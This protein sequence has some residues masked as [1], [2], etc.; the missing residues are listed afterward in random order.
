MDQVIIVG[1]G[2]AGVSAACWLA[3][4]GVKT[5]L[6]EQT[7]RLGGRAASFNYA[8][9]GEEIDYGHHVLMRACTATQDL[10]GL[11]G[12]A[13]VVRFQPRLRVP[14]RYP[15]G[16][17]AVYSSYLPG[18]LHLLPTL[19]RYSP[20][21][22]GARINVIRAGFSLLMQ[23]PQEEK[24][25][26]NWL[27]CHHQGKRAIATLWG[28]I[29]VAAL[30]ARP[31]AVSARA[32]RFVF[33]NGFFRV[34]KADIG[35]FTQPLSRV[36]APAV[37]FIERHGG[38]AFFNRKAEKVI[39]QDGKAVGVK[40]ADGTELSGDAVVIGVPPDRVLPLLPRE[41]REN[42]SFSWASKLSFSPI[43]NLH[44][45][46]DR[47]V[48]DEEFFIGVNSPVQA[49]FNVSCIHESSGPTHIVLSQSA[50]D[51]LL[52]LKNDKIISQ[53]LPALETFLPR[54]RKAK[55]IDALVVRHS[56][57]TFL[58]APGIERIRPFQRTP[59]AGLYLAGDYTRTGWPATI[60]GAVRSGKL[61][62]NTL[63]SDLQ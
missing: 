49:V 44:L 47:P 31:D 32:A 30:N 60:E 7:A 8:K 40:F 2:P 29:T 6:A 16:K 35:L 11:I 3:H 56:Q 12:A 4:A 45:W 36:F 54:I 39:V 41:W 15:D 62:A 59:I 14:I 38:A 10:L 24:T 50:A 33:T 27:R 19:L 61:A 48:M 63:L 28:P 26:A 21:P 53:L 55:L 9:V 1:G 52:P 25:F 42:Q 57:A 17:S 13:N 5:V 34:H 22:L 46:Y 51:E 37:R 18:A 43:V 23:Q 58:P 20:L